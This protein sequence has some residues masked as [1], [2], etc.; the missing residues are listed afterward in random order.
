MDGSELGPGVS[1]QVMDEVFT[2]VFC[3]RKTSV[4]GKG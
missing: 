2:S 3:S 4:M 1:S